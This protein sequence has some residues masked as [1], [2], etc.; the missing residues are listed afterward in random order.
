VIIVADQVNVSKEN[1]RAEGLERC[2]ISTSWANY[3][4]LDLVDV[5][6]RTISASIR[7]SHSLV[8]QRIAVI[9]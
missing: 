7:A 3:D 1:S 9:V 8:I 2:V 6:H 5:G 4:S